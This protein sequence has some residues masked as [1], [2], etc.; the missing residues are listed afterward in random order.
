MLYWNELQQRLIKYSWLVIDLMIDLYSKPILRPCVIQ[1]VR[2]STSVGANYSEAL[3]SISR[4][5]KAMKVCISR[6]ELNESIYWLSV[7]YK[8]FRKERRILVV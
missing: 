7:L 2:S 1:L 3:G 8:Y 4:R 6:K 5:E